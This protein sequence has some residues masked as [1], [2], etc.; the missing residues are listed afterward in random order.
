MT[1]RQQTMLLA[2]LAAVMVAV[3][4][5]AFLPSHRR[6]ATPSTGAASPSG[7]AAVTEQPV[8]VPALPDR[9]V[10][11]TAQQARA[12][13]LSWSRDPFTRGAVAGQESGLALSGILW[14]PQAPIAIING[15]MLHLGEELEGYRVTEITQERVSMTDGTQT[16][17]L[18]IAP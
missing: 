6:V 12:A 11:H 16:F 14:D 13:E 3:Y 9:S 4:A 5:R 8:A 18:M 1:R 15:Q 7:Q 17:Q 2:G 10:Q